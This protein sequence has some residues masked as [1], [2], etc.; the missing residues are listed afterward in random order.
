MGRT[1]VSAAKRAAATP[2]P[3]GTLGEVLAWVDGHTGR[4]RQLLAQLD[5]TPVNS[6][7]QAAVAA[8]KELVD[9]L[10]AVFPSFTLDG[11]T[12]RV[13]GELQLLDLC[14]LMRLNKRGVK[15]VDPVAVAALADFFQGALGADEYERFRS[16]CREHAVDP[17]VLS[18]IM[19]GVAEDLTE[20]P[21]SR[22]SHSVGGPSS[23]GHGSKV[24]S[25]S[26]PAPMSSDGFQDFLQ[27][28]TEPDPGPLGISMRDPQPP[29]EFVY[30]G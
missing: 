19:E 15:T 20:V 27:R 25:P 22:P 8:R 30:F 18:D 29:R 23:A 2:P 24:D 17:D 10:L 4:A 21:T 12:F 16:Y 26:A 5:A 9:A 3:A 1:Y 7:D 13:L 14:E 11:E 28:R 6:G